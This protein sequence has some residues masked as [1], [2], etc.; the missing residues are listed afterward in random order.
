M[1]QTT[2]DIKVNFYEPG[3]VVVHACHLIHNDNEII[4]LSG[5]L[6]QFVVKYDLKNVSASCKVSVLDTTNIL[7]N[8][9]LD[10]SES[11]KLS[12]NSDEDDIITG[13][14]GIYRKDVDVDRSQGAKG[15]IFTLYGLDTTNLKQMSLDIN[16]A[17]TGNISD[18]VKSIFKNINS[19]HQIE[20]DKTAGTKRRVLLIDLDP[21]GNA[22]TATGIKEEKTNTLYDL[23]FNNTPIISF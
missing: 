20:V 15:K 23:F 14:F 8:M 5:G 12:W 22:T 1:P 6:N 21:Q 3:N 19:N 11:I 17:F 7:G 18:H 2:D 10:G 16:R 4:D 13:E 9:N